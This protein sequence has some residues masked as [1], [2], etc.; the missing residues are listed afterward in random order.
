MSDSSFFDSSDLDDIAEYE[1]IMEINNED[2]DEV[3]AV[4]MR[5]YIN[6]ERDVAEER[7]MAD[8]FGPH[9]K[10]PAEYFRRRYRMNRELFLEIVQGIENYIQTVNP[11]PKHFQFFTIRYDCTGL[12]SFSV[13]MKCTSAIRQLAYGTTPDALD[14]YLQMGEHCARDCLNYFCMCVMDLYQPEFLRKPTLADI[15]NLYAAHNRIHGFPGMLGSIDCMHWEW[16][17]CPKSWHGQYGR[18]DKKYP[19]IILEAVASYDLWIWHAFFGVAGANNDITVLHHSPL[20]DDLLAD[21]EPVAPYV[22]NGQPFDKG[23]Y[24]AD[25]IY[26]QWSTFV[27]SFTVARD[28]KNALFKRRQESARKDVER[29]FGVLQGRWRIIAQPARAW[30]VNKLRRIMYTCIIILHQHDFKKSKASLLVNGS[31]SDEFHI[32]R[33]LKQ[34]DPLSPFL[35]ILVMEALH[36]SVCKAV[37][38][39]VFKGIQLQGSLALSHLFYADDAFFMGEWSDNN[40]RGIINILKCFHLASGLQINIHKSQI[41]GVGVSRSRVEDMASSLGC[42]IMENKFRYL[43]V[44]VGAGMTRHKAWDDVILKLQSRLSKW[45][46]KTLSIG[47]RLTLL[48]SVLGAS[49]LYN[50]SIFK[51]PKGVLKVMESIRSNFFKGASM[52]EKKISW[53]AWDKVL[54]S[55][56][57][58]GLGV[59]SYFALNRAL[60]L[61]WV[62]RFVSQDDSLWFRVIQAVHGD[63][64]DS[65]SVRKV[66]IWSSILKEVQVLKSS[67]FDFLSYCSK[68]IGDGQ[69]TSFWKETWIGDI[70]LCELCPR[71]FA[72]DSAPNICVAAKMAGPLDTSFRRSVRGG[73][74]QQEFSDLSSFLN[75]VVLSTYNDRWYFSLSSSGEFSVK[76]TRLAID[77]L[78]LPSHSEPT[79]WVKLIPIKINVFMWRARRGCLPTRYNLVQKGVI[80]ES[81]SCPIC[82]SEEEDVHH[83]LFRCSLSQEVLHRVCR[84]WEIDFQLWRSFSE[85][86]AWFSSIRL[87]GS[88]KGFLKGVFYVL[89]VEHVRRGRPTRAAN[90]RNTKRGNDPDPRD[91]EIER[92][93]QRIQE[94]E[95]LHHEED[96]EFDPTWNPSR[97]KTLLEGII[98][99]NEVVTV[100]IIYELKNSLMSLIGCE[101]AMMRMDMLLQAL[102]VEKQHNKSKGKTGVGRFTHV[103]KSTT[104]IVSIGLG[105]YARDCPNQIIVTFIDEEIQL[106]YDTDGKGDELVNNKELVCENVV[107]TEMV[108]KLGFESIKSSRAVSVDVVEEGECP[109]V[110]E[111]MKGGCFSWNDEAAKAFEL[112]KIKGVGIGGVLSQNQRPIAFFSENLSDARGK[113]S[114]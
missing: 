73:V 96:S 64:I 8:Y 16:V 95:L 71:L 66:S 81:T 51:V 17:N 47:G 38:E 31:P 62:W 100:M 11:L 108:K 65:H 105:H 84:W 39:D 112:L 5:T 50:M 110:A 53:I 72:L 94:L 28:E 99:I 29:A 57:K 90:F 93:Q 106:I 76:D 59:S 103:S 82:F 26:P 63:K 104:T 113:Y 97:M 41:L 88:V 2:Q 42:T 15:Q 77:D 78:V 68:R 34:G 67:G 18:G 19:T 33:G 43:G 109:P 21:N 14:E 37:D 25:G 48:K 83:L 75:S 36:L 80:L 87:P 107:S 92:L 70:P 12:K 22:V 52:L 23:Y 1:M 49:P 55:K 60:L 102:K 58:G 27:K 24:L 44:M 89:M 35:F 61:K 9:P 6:R 86:D 32:H 20:F 46:A 3:E 91:I 111:C 79:R 30:T 74:E 7:L 69:S 98:D 54:A 45:K 114:T 85:W 13:I 40:L 56:K 101:C 4:P 10:Y